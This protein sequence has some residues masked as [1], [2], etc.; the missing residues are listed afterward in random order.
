MAPA[1]SHKAVEALQ[2][3]TDRYVSWFAGGLGVRVSPSGAKTFVF[4]YRPKGGADKRRMTLGV[5]PEMS[6]AEANRRHLAARKAHAEGIDP[7]V[8]QRAQ[9][10]AKRA[11]L[12]A[13][14]KA[15]AAAGYT[16]RKLF[17]DWRRTDLAEQTLPNGKRAGRK[18]SG[19]A[20]AGQFET[21]VFPYIG[22]TRAVEVRRADVMGLLDRA[23]LAG[24]LRTANVLLANLRQMF[25]WAELRELVDR[26]PTVG[27][28][29]RDAGGEESPRDRVLS[30]DELRALAKAIPAANMEDRSVVAIWL[31]LATGA[32]VGETMLAEWKDI[33]LQARTWYLP[34]EATKTERDHTVHLSDFAVVQFQRLL[35]LRPNDSKGKPLPWVFP[36]RAGDGPVDVKSFGKQLADRQRPADK[37]LQGRSKGTTALLLA[38]GKWTP[39]DLRRTAATTMA[40]LGTSGDVIDECLNHA[41]ESRVRRAYVHDR[42]PVQQAEAFDALGRELERVLRAPSD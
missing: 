28:T 19:S 14:A 33:D 18:D 25:A 37:R 36:N 17:E 23:K 9:L 42:R 31:L 39:H 13:Q 5:F 8:Q 41:L 4:W 1:L 35:A 20:T 22:A 27:V 11:E 29:K 12:E 34:K 2:P 3:R 15:E 7:A 26:N 30:P 16:V 10:A 38:G 6:V 24:K 32:R 40:R 21:H